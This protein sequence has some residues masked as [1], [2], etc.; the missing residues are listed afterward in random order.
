[1]N[2]RNGKKKVKS[3]FFLVFACKSQDF[4]QSHE[5]FARSDDCETVTF[6]SSG[7]LEQQEN[8]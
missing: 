8:S 4:A 1:M 7:Y 5:N 3:Q 6:R 2:K